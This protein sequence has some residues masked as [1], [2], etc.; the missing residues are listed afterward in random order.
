MMEG[1][2]DL[3]IEIISPSNTMADIRLKINVAD[4][5]PK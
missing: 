1:A 4:I 3:A 2:P 5:F